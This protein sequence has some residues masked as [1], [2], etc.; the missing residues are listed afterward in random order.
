VTKKEI[1]KQISER[2]GL[3]QLKTKDIV[4]QTFDAIVETLLEVGRI[5]L[6]N[7]GVFEV[8]QRKARK[9]RNPRTGDSVD[10]PPKNVVTFKPGKEMEEK[11]RKMKNVASLA[12]D[13]D[14]ELVAEISN[15]LG[16]R[17]EPIGKSKVKTG[18]ARKSP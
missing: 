15:G 12:I 6:R 9:A 3:T 17:A 5:E 7:F 1:V 13:E 8:K 16:E 18:R 10:V 4:Q 2:I 11:V 14:D